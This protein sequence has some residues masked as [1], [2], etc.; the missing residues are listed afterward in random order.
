LTELSPLR[1]FG[2]WI[3]A[4]NFGV[5]RSRVKVTVKSNMLQNALFDLD[6]VVVTC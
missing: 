3:N 4:S 2:E 5:K 1:E 6:L